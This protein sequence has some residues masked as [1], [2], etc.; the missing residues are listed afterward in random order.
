MT[1][2][3][4]IKPNDTL[5]GIAI[6]NNIS[7]VELL[8][9]NPQYQPNPDLI[10]I[11]DSITLP[12]R[13]KPSSIEL[14]PV[15]PVDMNRPTE[16]GCAIA[17]PTCKGIEVCDVIF[18]TGDKTKDYFL[19]DK[20]AQKLLEEEISYTQ[21]LID[22]YEQILQKAPENNANQDS[23]AVAEHKA[24]RQKW[25]DM[26][27][28]SGAL[29]VKTQTEAQPTSEDD[30]F[31]NTIGIKRS[32]INKNTAQAKINELEERKKIIKTVITFEPTEI[33]LVDAL[34]SE[35]NTELK[36]QEYYIK[37]VA[38]T[39]ESSVKQGIN[40]KNFTSKDVV[41]TNKKQGIIEIFIVSQNKLVY[42]RQDFMAREQPFWRHSTNHTHL[43][44]A[45]SSGN[46]K[47]MGK[48]IS[49]DI[50]NGMTDGIKNT[51]DGQFE[52]KIIGWQVPGY[53]LKEWKANKEFKDANGATVYAV[54]AEA[55]LLRFAAQA[56]V[57]GDFNLKQAKFDLGFAAESSASLAEGA[58]TFN[59]YFPH[60]KGYS[61]LITYTDAD[62]KPALYPLGHFRCSATLT[63]S[64]LVTAMV[65]GKAMISNQA[66]KS[67]GTGVIFSPQPT[68]AV[69]PSG[70]IGVSAEGFAGAQAG[71]Q[72]SGKVEWLTPQ[73]TGTTDFSA[74]V[75][76]KA[77]G[78]VA[79]G[80][81]VGVDF[82]IRLDRGSLE[83][84][85]SARLVWG[86]GASG[87]F[88][89]SIDFSQLFELAKI[90]W[91]AI[92]TIGYRIMGN[93]NEEAYTYLFRAAFSA[94]TEKDFKP[95][96]D[97]IE[98]GTRK[99]DTWWLDR[100]DH[101]NENLFISDEAKRLTK[102]ILDR[103]RKVLSGV[104]LKVL[105]PE[106]VGMMLNTLVHTYWL[107]LEE[108]QE[109]AIYVLLSGTI[110]SWRKFVEV[111]AHMNVEGK[112]H[113]SDDALVKNLQRINY[114]LDG[115]QQKE[116]NQW[117]AQLASVNYL[118]NMGMIPSTPFTIYD[119]QHRKQKKRELKI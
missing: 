102:R 1:N 67:A 76:I 36:R 17:R 11:N 45:V 109:A 61:A 27:I 13:E 80:L 2:I 37:A 30:P 92:D 42:I 104:S 32:D 39:D 99:I 12:N 35:I 98:I 48:A 21:Q 78:N 26:A 6:K 77:E 22:G 18:K 43:N 71:G 50:T 70:Q 53:K 31:V 87:G 116:F 88:G 66:E 83:I 117:I 20:H 84:H 108:E 55:Q 3:Y 103:E 52:G 118:D 47:E 110:R 46:W 16:G 73:K 75:E 89:T 74:L 82:Q 90:I 14:K 19:L 10:N 69:K 29:P 15:E 34:I 65:N 62:R 5:L 8:E 100:I 54:S 115:D 41:L 63:L 59:S 105:P 113:S 93:I 119:F 24:M 64:C 44:Q 40:Q 49:S 60:E 38:S 106:T 33:T 85:C 112:K 23:A 86:P 91:E 68:M 57:K 96:E 7:L 97:A 107:N 9:I 95:I 56:S 114:I 111:L 25:Y 101:I 94:F 72:L 79:F 28:S 4:T 81:G 51:I 58:V